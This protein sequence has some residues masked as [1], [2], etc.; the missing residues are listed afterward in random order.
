MTDLITTK[1][2]QTELGVTYR[3]LWYAIDR[4]SNI[5]RHGSGADIYLTKEEAD[6]LRDYFSRCRRCGQK[7]PKGDSSA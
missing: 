6:L 4:H 5:E 2:L 1:E 7:L 3:R